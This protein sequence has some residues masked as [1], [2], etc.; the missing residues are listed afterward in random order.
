MENPL[1]P[2]Q[3]QKLKLLKAKDL[4]ETFFSKDQHCSFSFHS[5]PIKLYSNS[6]TFLDL[7]KNYIP[8]KWQSTSLRETNEIFHSPP[9]IKLKQIFDDEASSLVSEEFTEENINVIAQRDFVASNSKTD[10]SVKTIFPPEI[11]DGFHNF[12]RWYLSPKLI[13]HKKAMLHCSAVLDRFGKANLFLGPSGAGKT[14]ITS[15]SEER[16]TL[17]DDMNLIAIEDNQLV[18]YPGGVGGLYKPQVPINQSFSIANIYWLKQSDQDKAE[19]LSKITQQRFLIASLA[20]L[21]WKSFKPSFQEQIL[22]LVD[23]VL[24]LKEIQLL[25][26][27]KDVSI[28]H[29]LDS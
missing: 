22:D 28:W 25:E 26:F 18:V 13:P 17:S 12:F 14:T 8:K 29:F 2:I 11:D 23:H 7:V 1:G 3:N 15:L 4:S 24:K 6:S 16:I 5:L 21:N 9:S 20:N 27:K 10:G 19:N